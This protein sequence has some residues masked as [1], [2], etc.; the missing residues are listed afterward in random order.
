MK[1][2]FIGDA[3]LYDDLYEKIFLA[4]DIFSDNSVRGSTPLSNFLDEELIN[5]KRILK[6][7]IDILRYFGVIK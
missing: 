3:K 6:N 7:G 1:K 2:E 5:I 4:N